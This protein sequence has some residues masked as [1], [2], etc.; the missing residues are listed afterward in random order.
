MCGRYYIAQDDRDE[1]YRRIVERLNRRALGQT[2]T[3]KQS[4][5]IFPTNVVP[6]LV[7]GE[8]K[9][10]A[11]ALKWGYQ[12]ERQGKKTL[13]INARAETAARLPLFRAS[14]AAAA[15][16]CL[17]PAS[18]YFEWQGDGKARPKTRYALRPSGKGLFYLCGLARSIREEA[19]REK[20]PAERAE[21]VRL[22][23]DP[24]PPSSRHRTF[25]ILTRP[26]APEIASIH[27]RM[28]LILPDSLAMAWLDDRADPGALLQ[29]AMENR[30]P[31]EAKEG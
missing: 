7:A 14:W 31:M 28:P 6:A 12:L 24:L 1:A 23:A 17:L 26:A 3:L 2:E 13:L 8:G 4:G 18:H 11:V 10:D 16:R 15:G 21:Q 27:D 9:P 22:F 29:A 5:E 19:E 25:V 30:V 20:A